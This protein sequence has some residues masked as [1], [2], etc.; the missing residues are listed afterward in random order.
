MLFAAFLA[1]ND[2]LIHPTEK[3]A[4]TLDDCEELA[5]HEGDPDAWHTA[6]RYASHML[7]GIFKPQDPLLQVRFAPE[8]HQAL[9][10]VLDDIPHPTYA[11][12]DGLGWVYQ[13]WQTKRKKQ[14]NASG[15][16]IGGAD[17]SPRHPALHRALHGAVPTAQHPR[18]LVGRAA[19]RQAAPHR[20]ELPAD[21]GRRHA[22]RR[23][24]RG[25]ARP[26]AR[27]HRHGPLLRLG[28]LPGRGLRPDEALPDDRGGPVGGRGR[29]RGHPRQP[30]RARA[31][32]PLHPDRRL[33]PGARSLEDR[34]ATDSCPP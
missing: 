16:K 24:V 7:P 29:R 30:P 28:S 18:R 13:F 14:V 2:L 20:Q 27:H 23:N 10:R 17:I 32:P 6:A 33:Q 8:D 3:V 11:S 15:A 31:R 4:V 19:P 22:G 9:E 21:A 12:D 5:A 34:A 26:G 1:H 25:L